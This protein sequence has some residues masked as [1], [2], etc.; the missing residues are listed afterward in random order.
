[1]KR[2]FFG[3][4]KIRVGIIGMGFIGEV[5]MKN[6]MKD[7]RVD[8]IGVM[9]AN[10]DR[11]RYVTNK[12]NVKR[13]LTLEE[14]RN[15]GI[16][17]VYITTPNRTHFELAFQAVK[18]GFHVFCEKPMTISLSDAKTLRQYVL[19]KKVKFQVGHNRIFA[20]VYKYAKHAIDTREIVPYSFQV[21]MN[22]GE[23]LDPPWVSDKNITGG[24]LFESTLH[25]F[26]IVE[27][28]FGKIKEMHVF[29]KKSIYDDFDDW[30][31]VMKSSSG[32]IGTFVSSAHTGWMVPFERVEIYGKHMMISNDEMERLSFNRGLEAE[33]EIHDYSKMPF[34][35]KWGYVEE[36]RS[37]IT[38]ILENKQPF[39]TVSDGLRA[40]EIVDAC[41]KAAR[42]NEP[43]V[44][45]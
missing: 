3:I 31:F 22:R 18:Q 17:A 9:E 38:S 20:Y 11:A 12:F 25:L 29:A 27:Y 5:H 37:F 45:F 32:I 13:F 44:K 28:L 6:L 21:K 7:E 43:V 33:T 30:A 41:Y 8:L 39:V 15:S 36:D 35:K 10:N 40:V 14:M 2:S 26:Y 19:G 24:F 42:E 23:L 16:E 34:E 1:M 4:R